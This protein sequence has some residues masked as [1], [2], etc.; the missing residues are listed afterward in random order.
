ME[1]NFEFR[2]EYYPSFFSIYIKGEFDID[3]TKL[4]DNDIGTLAHEYC[5]YLQNIET[6]AGIVSSQSFFSLVLELREYIRT[7][8]NNIEIPIK[9]FNLSQETITNKAS[10][11]KYKGYSTPNRTIVFDDIEISSNTEVP[12]V[13]F[14]NENAKVEKIEF[15]NLCVKEGMAHMFQQLFDSNVKHDTLPYLIVERICKKKCPKLLEAPKKIILLSFVSL[16]CCFNSGKTFINL[17]NEVSS[18]E[19]YYLELTDLEFYKSIHESLK[20][21]INGRQYEYLN[22]AKLETLASLEETMEN[23]LLSEMKYF[24]SIFDNIR[25][26]N[27]GETRGFAEILTDESL[28]KYD[29]LTELFQNYKSPNIR[30]LGHKNIF[31]DTSSELIELVGQKL[32]LDRVLSGKDVCTYLPFCQNQ[33]DDITGDQCY[34]IEA[35]CEQECPYTLTY[36]LWDIK[37][38]SR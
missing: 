10:I 24:K 3:F 7:H 21:I 5:H 38:K 12:I 31:P 29:I 19:D 4:S 26:I 36:K 17:I 22:E 27:V 2:G 30:T 11:D 28:N 32:V 23:S 35:T 6:I 33:D 15:G 37:S 25:G 13:E 34:G 20:P 8:N 16:E 1:T 18:R 14:F 9:D